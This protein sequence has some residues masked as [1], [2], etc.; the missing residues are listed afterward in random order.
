M[1]PERE[2]RN[3]EVREL[4]KEAKA[5]LATHEWCGEVTEVKLA[6]AVA[7]V[8]G[9]FEV[10]LA[11]TRPE[12]DAVL[13][14]VVGDI[15]PAYLVQDEAP[16][17]KDALRGYVLEMHRWVHAVRHKLPLDDVIPVEAEP[18][19]DHAEMLASRL[20]FIETEILEAADGEIE[21][22]D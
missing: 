19:A 7:G 21:S 16:T 4:A 9:V 20:A 13:W 10:E 12:V 8:L 14:V 15:P 1:F 11:P 6:F 2:I 22:D 17:W 5:F 3:S 18:T